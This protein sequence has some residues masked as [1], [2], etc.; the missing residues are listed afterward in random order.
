MS[1]DITGLVTSLKQA[2]EHFKNFD[3]PITCKLGWGLLWR[4]CATVEQARQ[5]YAPDSTSSSKAKWGEQK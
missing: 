4:K 1:E 5:F 2:E 3:S